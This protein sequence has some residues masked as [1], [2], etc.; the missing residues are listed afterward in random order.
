MIELRFESGDLLGTPLQD[1]LGDW[2]FMLKMGTVCLEW[3]SVC[4]FSSKENS[5]RKLTSIVPLQ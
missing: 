4:L 1:F 5:V 3:L 2:D